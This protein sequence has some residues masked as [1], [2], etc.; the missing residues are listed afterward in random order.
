M[1]AQERP[2]PLKNV[3]YMGDGP[4]DIPCMSIVQRAKGYVIGIL[5]KQ[6]PNRSWALAYGRR[7]YITVPPDF[8]P[9]EHGFVQLRQAVMQIAERIKADLE[10]Y[11]RFGG[12][13]P[14]Y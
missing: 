12:P 4:S 10:Y 9:G 1:D 7:A 8:R 11:Q 6:E 2:I 13:T 5:S 14:T 3:I